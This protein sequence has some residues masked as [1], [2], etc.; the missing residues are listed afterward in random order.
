MAAG[1][2]TL[3]GR[4]YPINPQKYRGDSKE[5]VYRSSW[6]LAVMSRFDKDIRIKWWSSEEFVIKYWNPVKGREARYFPDFVIGVQ[7]G[8]VERIIMIEVK[9]HAETLPPKP[10]KKNH[11][12]SMQ[13]Y[14]SE[15]DTFA[16]NQAK[17]KA[18]RELCQRKGLHFQIFTEYEIGLK[19]RPQKS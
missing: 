2:R 16:V 11:A 12:K 5:I 7:H 13:R 8:D 19:K 14:L 1:R 3:Q 4:F 6:E 18:A 15:Q 17:W 9:P 10:P